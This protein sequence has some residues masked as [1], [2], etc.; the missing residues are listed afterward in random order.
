V[1]L[2]LT[3]TAALLV[4][5]CFTAAAPAEAGPGTC[6][7]SIQTAI[8][9]AAPGATVT[10]PA[11]VCNV[12]NGLTI[13]GKAITLQGSSGSVLSG[14]TLTAGHRILTLTNAADTTVRDITF[15]DANQPSVNGPA[16][17]VELQSGPLL[18]GLQFYGNHGASG[19]AVS[20]NATAG[21]LDSPVTV[22]DSTF[23]STSSGDANTATTAGGGVFASGVREDRVEGSRFIG[24]SAPQGG[25]AEFGASGDLTIESSLFERNK[26][27]GGAGG[28]YVSNAPLTTFSGNTF[29]GNQAGE[30]GSVEGFGGAV[31][32]GSGPADAVTQSGNLFEDN[33]SIYQPSSIDSI[34]AEGVHLGSFTSR[35]DRFIGNRAEAPTTGDAEGSALSVEACAPNV[36]TARVESLVAAGNTITGAGGGNREGAVYFGCANGPVNVTVLDSTIAGN[37]SGGSGTAGLFGGPDDTLTMQNSIVAGNVGGGDLTG[38]SSKAV[39]FSDACPLLSGTGNLCANPLLVNPATGDVHQTSAS[40]TLD[41]GSNALIPAGLT[42]DFEGQAR[43]QGAAVDMGADETAPATAVAD[44]TPPGVTGASIG[45]AFAVAKGSTPITGQAAA[46]RKRKKK[47]K[48]G[49]TIRYSLSEA[50]TVRLTIERASKGRRVK[51]KGKKARCVK[52]TR[53]NHKKRRCTRYK[54]AGKT[55]VRSSKAGKNKVK[56]SGRLGRKALKRGSYRLTI[57]ATDAA[58]NKSKAKRLKFRIVK[59]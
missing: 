34:G 54:R 25:A 42:T 31:F 3:T 37:N 51:R 50:A 4:A 6:E 1:R 55:L 30:P 27:T 41:K 13:S 45:K 15:R 11:A 32:V 53:K 39:G 10:V 17:Y 59:P 40:P 35:N 57:V 8:N 43:I 47:V 2:R 7:G 29:R 38:F 44:K 48:R 49:T 9:A 20:I 12:T 52:Q 18:D 24:N 16:V 28:V 23:G 58:G 56:F 36:G 14:S 46:K 26:A 22:R 21:G 5:G 19:G 33:V